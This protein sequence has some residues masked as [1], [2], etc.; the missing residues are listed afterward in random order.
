N[1]FRSQCTATTF[2]TGWRERVPEFKGRYTEV[3]PG[4]EATRATARLPG[5]DIEIARWR[6]V[7]GDAEQISI[8]LRAAPSFE[9]VGRALETANPFAFWVQSVQLAWLPWL[10]TAR[11]LA[12]PWTFM[13]SL[14]SPT[15]DGASHS[16]QPSGPGPVS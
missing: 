1:C 6:A 7:E 9:A 12:L 10:E 16:A 8:N 14:P 11:V 5:L 4:T 2:G 3:P 13:R 15:S